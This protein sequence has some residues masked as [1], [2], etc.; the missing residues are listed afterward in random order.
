MDKLNYGRYDNANLDIAFSTTNGYYNPTSELDTRKQL[1]YPLKEIKTY[2]STLVDDLY[3]HA[4]DSVSLTTVICAGILT[5]TKNLVR[6]FIPLSKPIDATS[7]S[8]TSMTLTTRSVSGGSIINSQNVIG[9][10]DYTVAF[11]KKANGIYVQITL[12]NPASSETNNTPL[13]VQIE[14]ATITF[15]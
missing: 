1:S 3:Y 5:G 9:S 4:G 13:N 2:L 14:N 10:L 8:A 7:V 15:A 6:F 11:T 12:T